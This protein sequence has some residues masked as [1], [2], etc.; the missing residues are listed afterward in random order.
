MHRAEEVDF[1]VQ[2]E[3]AV[4]AGREQGITLGWPGRRPRKQDPNRTNRGC[5]PPPSHAVAF[6]T[7]NN[8]GR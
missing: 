2:R 7:L 1:T 5:Q 3:Q 6:L 8:R 4:V